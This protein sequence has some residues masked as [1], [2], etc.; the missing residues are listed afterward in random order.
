MPGNLGGGGMPGNLGGGASP[1]E[2]D[3]PAVF[4]ALR[5]HSPAF[6]QLAAHVMNTELREFFLGEVK[7]EENA[8][9]P[10]DSGN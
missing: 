2:S 9:E 5:S 3:G 4:E 10:E 6:M 8:V 7:P 1:F